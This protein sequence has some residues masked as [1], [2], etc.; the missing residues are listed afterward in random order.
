[1]KRFGAGLTRLL[2]L[3]FCLIPAVLLTWALTRS[4]LRIWDIPAPFWQLLGI[5]VLASTVF[6]VFFTNVKTLLAGLILLL[7]TCAA[8][9]F[10]GAYAGVFAL[11]SEPGLPL[12]AA[13][14]AAAALLITIFS[15]KRIMLPPLIILSGGSFLILSVAGFAPGLPETAAVCIALIAYTARSALHRWNSVTSAESEGHLALWILPVATVLAAAMLFLVTSVSLPRS[16]YL[17]QKLEYLN[18]YAMEL[19]GSSDP[20][21]SFSLIPTGMQ[22]DPQ[23]LGGPVQLQEDAVLEIV[24]N[25]TDILL[26]GAVYADYNGHIWYNDAS[27]N[28]YRMSDSDTAADVF[29]RG[30]PREGG[31][32]FRDLR[33]TITHLADGPSSLFVPFRVGVITPSEVMTLLVYFNDRGEVFSSQDIQKGICYKVESSLPADSLDILAQWMQNH[34]HVTD[35]EYA[36]ARADYL[37]VLAS[38][39]VSVRELAK[40][41]AAD[42]TNDAEAVLALAKYLSANTIYSLDPVVP[43]ADEDFVAHFLDTKVGYCTYYASAMTIM[44]RTLGIPARYVEGYQLP[45]NAKPDEVITITQAQAHAWCEVYLKGIGWIPVDVSA[46]DEYST[47]REEEASSQ[48]NIPEILPEPTP[49]PAS[50]PTP[51]PKPEN[52]KQQPENPV[53]FPWKPIV[54]ILGVFFLIAV[55]LAGPPMIRRSL[56]KRACSTLSGSIACQY[57]AILRLLSFVEL[58]PQIGETP[59]RFAARVDQLMPMRRTMTEVAQVMMDLTYGPN[60]TPSQ[61][62]AEILTHYRHRLDRAI[63][64]GKGWWFYTLRETL[65]LKK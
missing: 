47:L 60:P 36:F 22:P 27:V 11:L 9:F 40:S 62:Q 52:N 51:T 39:P 2:G 5:S 54:S 18:H 33:L 46:K 64:A 17:A 10:T 15:R 13:L 31:L 49:T 61:Q 23:Q 16:D 32:T 37:S 1:M 24:T 57:R 38:L 65:R 20:R 63:R 34:D 28:R 44:S 30:L 59:A 48:E 26:R 3:L 8:L 41:L 12:T 55:T 35:P 6:A 21:T 45:E 7:A 58:T 50:K 56:E 14:A 19:L 43:P 53:S 42:T 4:V 25:D 29:N